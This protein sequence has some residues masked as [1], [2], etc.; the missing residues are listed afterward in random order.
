MGMERLILALERNDLF[1][2]PEFDCTLYIA[3]IGEKADFEAQ[4]LV[5]KLR[6]DGISCEK[7]LSGR[8]FKAQMK[9]A[10]K[11][12]VKYVLVLG[13]DEIETGKAKLKNM[14]TGEQTD[15]ELDNLTC[16]LKEEI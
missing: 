16:I 5:T 8:S 7:D 14:A 12:G 3:N 4:K 9:Y 10:D 1:P 15:V 11:I 13:E 6:S 2:K